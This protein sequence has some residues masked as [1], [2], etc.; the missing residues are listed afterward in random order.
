[1]FPKPKDIAGRVV[2]NKAGWQKMRWQVFVSASSGGG[3]SC[4]KCG[5]RL[6]WKVTEAAEFGNYECHHRGGRGLGGSKRDDRE[7]VPGDED[8]YE[9][10]PFMP[11]S[12]AGMKRNLFATC[13]GCH[14]V[15]HNQGCSGELQWGKSNPDASQERERLDAPGAGKRRDCQ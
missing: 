13:N 4:M 14:R 11:E 1:M 6:E 15:E 10:W 2:L 12:P 8:Q 3:S 7:F 9:E 5:A